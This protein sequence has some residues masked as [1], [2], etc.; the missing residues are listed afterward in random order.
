MKQISMIPFL[1]K[2]VKLKKYSF[3]GDNPSIFKNNVV[4]QNVDIASEVNWHHAFWQKYKLITADFLMNGI[5]Q[6]LSL[7]AVLVY[8]IANFMLSL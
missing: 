3:G 5:F 8:S 1:S 6:I 2:I 7:K 4:L